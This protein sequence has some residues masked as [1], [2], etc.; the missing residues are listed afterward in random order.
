[1]HKSKGFTLIELIISMLLSIT[2][3]LAFFSLFERFE[4]WTLN[5]NLMLERDENLWLSP[6]L[7]SR[8]ITPA[9]NNW[10]TDSWTGLTIE[11]EEIGVSSDMEGP[12]GFPDSQL[13]S[14]F[15]RIT[16]RQR[17]SELQ[18]KSGN[19]SFQPVLENISR[20]QVNSQNLPL[21]QSSGLGGYGASPLASQ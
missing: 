13:S 8:W 17:N 19:G 12:D 18:L 14:P 2:L 5:L 6:L 11:P 21:H 3:F 9:G 15:E 10:W 20:L 4:I 1:M 16:L 7:L